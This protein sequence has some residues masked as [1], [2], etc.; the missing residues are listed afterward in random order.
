[1]RRR[2]R[3]SINSQIPA[4]SLLGTLIL[5]PACASSADAIDQPRATDRSESTEV[6]TIQQ[7]R[8]AT[9]KRVEV[10]QL[11]H[12]TANELAALL[13]DLIRDATAGVE[14]PDA[15]RAVANPNTNSIIVFGDDA[16]RTRIMTLVARLDIPVDQ[17]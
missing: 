13:S 17:E 15:P 2:T 14:R 10:I 16:E 8:P 7:P 1:M 11:E 9:R 4:L 3:R 5:L 12:A 6:S